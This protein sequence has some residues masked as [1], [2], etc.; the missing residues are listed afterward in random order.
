[1]SE[2]FARGAGKTLG[3]LNH[4]LTTCPATDGTDAMRYCL[5][6]LGSLPT[7]PA[8]TSKVLSAESVAACERIEMDIAASR[9]AG[10]SAMMLPDGRALVFDPAFLSKKLE[11]QFFSR[12]P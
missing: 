12:K 3:V 2:L 1:M 9:V 6:S 8:F 7:V 5:E 10:L 4:I 11:A